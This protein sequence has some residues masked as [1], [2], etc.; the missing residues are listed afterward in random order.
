MKAQFFFFNIEGNGEFFSGITPLRC[1]TT[2]HGY[3]SKR[4]YGKVVRKQKMD[5][6]MVG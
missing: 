5:S 4:T 1:I 3:Q 2:K 6:Y